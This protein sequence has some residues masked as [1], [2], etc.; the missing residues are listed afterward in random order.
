[1]III[2]WQPIETAPKDGTHILIC[3]ATDAYGKLTDNWVDVAAWSRDKTTERQWWM[4]VGGV[5][6]GIEPTHW[7][8]IPLNPLIPYPLIPP[9]DDIT[10]TGAE[11]TGIILGRLRRLGAKDQKPTTLTAVLGDVGKAISFLSRIQEKLRQVDEEKF[12]GLKK[13]AVDMFFDEIHAQFYLDPDNPLDPVWIE[14]VSDGL[15]A[16][17]RDATFS[18]S[19]LIDNVVEDA[20]EIASE[21]SKAEERDRPAKGMAALEKALR[22]A[23]DK[24]GACIKAYAGEKDGSS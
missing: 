6:S 23:A 16:D 13:E 7:M 5:I 2:G 10:I 8:P 17:P 22:V 14:V 11:Q 3:Q 19:E 21:T 4:T 1:M 15:A 18:F 9:Q 24:I 12:E 20:L